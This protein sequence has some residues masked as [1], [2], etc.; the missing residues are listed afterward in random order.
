MQISKKE[1]KSYYGR[2]VEGKRKT[3]NNETNKNSNLEQTLQQIFGRLTNLDERIT[4]VEYS[5]KEAIPKSLGKWQVIFKTIRT[6]L[7]QR[8]EDMHE[9]SKDEIHYALRKMK[10][11]RAPS[12]NGIVIEL[13]KLS[14]PILIIQF[15]TK[16]CDK[17]NLVNYRPS[18][19]LSHFY[20][21]CTRIINTRQYRE[22]KKQKRR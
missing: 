19:L 9:L 21:L 6:L 16:R 18:S 14:G 22:N 3:E 10:N 2:I 20:K 7:N 13:M 12:E 4:K 5:T 17:A 1:S 11:N 8:S 15:S